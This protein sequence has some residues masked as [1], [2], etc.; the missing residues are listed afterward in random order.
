MRRLNLAIPLSLLL[1]LMTAYALMGRSHLYGGDDQICSNVAWNLVANGTLKY[2][3]D[4]DHLTPSKFALGQVLLCL[5]AAYS[6]HVATTVRGEPLRYTWHVL[7]PCLYGGLLAA[8]TALLLAGIVM[9]MGYGRAVS[10]WVGLAFGLGTMVWPATHRLTGDA[11]QGLFLALIVWAVLRWRRSGAF[12]YILIAGIANAWVVLLKPTGL[13]LAGL[14]CG[15]LVWEVRR[16][17][18][19]DRRR[20]GTILGHRATLTG[21]GFLLAAIACMLAY[22]AW[23]YGDWLR[24]GYDDSGDVRGFSVPLLTGLYGLLFSSGKGVFWYN[25]VLLIAVLGLPGFLRRHPEVGCFSLAA[26][27]AQLLLHAGWWS[28]S[29]DNFWGPR[30]LLAVLPLMLL[31]GAEYLHRV[32]TA[33]RSAGR[34]IRQIACGV[35]LMLSIGVQQLGLLIIADE[36]IGDMALNWRLHPTTVLLEEAWPAG[37]DQAARLFV[38][39][40][41]PLAG[42]LWAARLLARA[43]S[44]WQELYRRPPQVYPTIWIDP[45]PERPPYTWGVWWLFAR[46]VGHPHAGMLSA[47]AVFLAMALVIQCLWLARLVRRRG[48][49]PDVRGTGASP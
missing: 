34:V 21:A 48:A 11:A 7:W 41:S 28:W 25:P 19:V 29:G 47:A 33:E 12:G 43:D 20:W 35:L 2:G 45:V 30:F 14:A 26:V 42:H 31:P 10:V 44:D 6:Y 18:P 22:N 16:R 38:P 17:L 40:Y 9:E 49:E 3:H 4:V 27:V 5:P 13:A 37:D 23:R 8:L 36:Y 46:Q 1:I 24:F 39:G 32:W 15:W